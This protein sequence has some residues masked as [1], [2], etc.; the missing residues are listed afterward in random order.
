MKVDIY[1]NIRWSRY[2]AQVFSALHQLA[3]AE[4]VD[5]RFTQ[6][7]DTSSSRISISG[8]E[9]DEHQYPHTLLFS[10]SYD[11]VPKWKLISTLFRRVWRSDADLILIPGYDQIAHWAMLLAALISGKRRGVFVDSTLSDRPQSLFKAPLKRLF[12]NLCHVYF[13]YGQRSGELLKY[14]GGQQD[15]IFT[16]CQ[17][18]AL[19]FGYS[20][21]LALKAR[22]VSAPKPLHPRFLY[23][24]RL[25]PLKSI[26]VLIEAF[27]LLIKKV[28]SA[29][30]VLVGSGPQEIV[31]RELVA[32]YGLQESVEFTGSMNQTELAEQYTRATCLILPSISEAWGLVVNEALHYGCP[33]VVS[34]R[35]GCVPELVIDGVSGFEFSAREP[36][37]LA[38]KLALVVSEFTNTEEVANRC[39]NVIGNYTPAT[40]AQ[41]ILQGCHY[42]LST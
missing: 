8:V 32:Q 38:S 6:I 33:V 4:E 7:A 5:I 37:D 26:D 16:G 35:C 22:I 24:G 36:N 17:A 30:L 20:A 23:V 28:P 11:S 19:P 13:G 9:L 12:F 25:I 1:H 27:G 10:G 39:L 42:A 29:Q 21:E 40:A 3:Q 31:L 14:Y 18:A 41:R 2:K 34:N 15:R